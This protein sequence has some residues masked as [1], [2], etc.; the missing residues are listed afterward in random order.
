MNKLTKALFAGAAMAG[1]AVTGASAQSNQ[2]HCS[3]SILPSGI[4]DFFTGLSGGFTFTGILGTIFT[5]VIAIIVIYIL[6]QIIKATFEWIGKSND[7]KARGAAIKSITNA[8]VAGIVLIIALIVVVIGARIFGVN[9]IPA[10]SYACYNDSD[11]AKLDK[12]TGTVTNANEYSNAQ[13]IEGQG[14]KNHKLSDYQA[15]VSNSS[16][17]GTL[18]NEVYCK[19]KSTGQEVTGYFVAKRLAI[20]K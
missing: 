10:V 15:R 13:A 5:F 20:V 7:E 18:A 16:L 6:F 8:V 14:T 3:G 12:A 4:C 19:D 17:A 2:I 11:I 9:D 1:V